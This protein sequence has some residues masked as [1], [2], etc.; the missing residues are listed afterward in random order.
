MAGW[1]SSHKAM[2]R[3]MNFNCTFPDFLVD[4]VDC[5]GS[6]VLPGAGWLED[7]PSPPASTTDPTAPPKRKRT[8][9]VV[10]S[11]FKQEFTTRPELVQCRLA[12][13]WWK[14]SSAVDDTSLHRHE[15]ITL[16]PSQRGN[17]NCVMCC[18]RCF[19]IDGGVISRTTYH[20]G[21]EETPGRIA[22]RDHFRRGHNA[23]CMCSRA[24]E[25]VCLRMLD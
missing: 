4:A 7:V 16:T 18:R 1:C 25:F 19:T 23:S 24:R 10:K 8:D 22:K 2:K 11:K 5:I 15:K 6:F 21:T 13:K 9:K 14:L 12:P 20:D 3:R 17:V